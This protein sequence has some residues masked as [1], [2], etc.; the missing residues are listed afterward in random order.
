MR[1]RER[2]QKG[3][4]RFNSPKLGPP[5]RWSRLCKF[6]LNPLLVQVNFCLLHRQR[7]RANCGSG[8]AEGETG[9]ECKG[10]D[11]EPHLYLND[12]VVLRRIGQTNFVKVKGTCAKFSV[13]PDQKI[14]C[15]GGMFYEVKGVVPGDDP[16]S[17]NHP[18]H[19]NLSLD[20]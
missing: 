8:A 14:R 1:T 19:E 3:R 16:R 10:I 20:D 7:A 2:T 11:E 6:A 12:V 18:I 9:R 13:A 17:R 5:P 15:R 4:V